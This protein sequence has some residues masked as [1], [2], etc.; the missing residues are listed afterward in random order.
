MEATS[1]T[2][3]P[4]KKPRCYLIYALAPE[5]LS[6]AEV[7]RTFNAFVADTSLPLAL[8][9]DHFIGERGG[10]ALFYV[11]SP[12]EQEVLFSSP[13]LRGW[14]VDFRP[15]IFSFSPGAFDEQIAFTLKQYRNEKWET[16][17][18]EKRPAY[19]D[20]RKEA[21]TAVEDEYGYSV[22]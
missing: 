10:V 11:A 9:H 17:R 13:H 7:N 16:L 22:G 2:S 5:T 14:N 4:T 20:P 15:L 12:E 19:G 3:V 18:R 21:E 6:A 1:Y 8:Y